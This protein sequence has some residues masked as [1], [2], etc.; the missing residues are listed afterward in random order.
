[1]FCTGCGREIAADDRFCGRCG[2]SVDGSAP[3]Q[4]SGSPPKRLFR[5]M[6]DKSIAGVCSGWARYLGIDVSVMRLIWVGV[7]FC[8]GMG[9]F[10]YPICWIVMQRDDVGVPAAPH[11][12]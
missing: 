1:M 3:F 12:A 5:S 8:T 4:A 6:R 7:T 9:F 2:R 10:V 11:M